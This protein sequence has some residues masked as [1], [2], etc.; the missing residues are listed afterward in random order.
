MISKNIVLNGNFI[1]VLI[2]KD[3]CCHFLYLLESMFNYPKIKNMFSI[4]NK[5]HNLEQHEDCVTMGNVALI[6]FD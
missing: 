2:S 3:E 1:H 6:S 4:L 5:C